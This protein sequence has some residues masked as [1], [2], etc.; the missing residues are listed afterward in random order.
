MSARIPP[1]PHPEDR[2]KAGTGAVVLKMSDLSPDVHPRGG[3]K[4]E[5][6]LLRMGARSLDELHRRGGVKA[7]TGAVLLR[8]G[9]GSPVKANPRARVKA[10]TVAVPPRRSV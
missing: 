2:V 8:A 5:A 7:G 10:E 9:D 6:V 4:A 1:D 3:V